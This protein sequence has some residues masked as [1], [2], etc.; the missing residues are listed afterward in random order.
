[1]ID[2]FPYDAWDE[3]HH[4]VLDLRAGELDRGTY[5]LTALGVIAHGGLADLLGVAREQEA[6]TQAALLAARAACP[7]EPDGA[8]ARFPEPPL[9]GPSTDPGP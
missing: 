6:E 4:D 2:S 9:A 3:R 7:R 5:I 1:M 8:R